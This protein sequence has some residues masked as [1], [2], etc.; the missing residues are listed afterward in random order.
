MILS[1]ALMK[2]K[3]VL[4]PARSTMTDEVVID[5]SALQS[6]V[7]ALRPE[8]LPEKHEVGRYLMCGL[9][10]CNILGQPLCSKN[11]KICPG[12][13][14]CKASF[15]PKKRWSVVAYRYGRTNFKM[16]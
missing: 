3:R 8:Q 7:D 6:L 12:Y 15:K 9:E 1:K 2:A 14:K 16:Y 11:S 5:R 4:D 13:K 10:T